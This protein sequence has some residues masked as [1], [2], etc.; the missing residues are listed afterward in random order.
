MKIQPLQMRG[1]HIIYVN[2]DYHY[3]QRY[4]LRTFFHHV[5]TRKSEHA[6]YRKWLH[7]IIC[8][9]HTTANWNKAHI[10]ITAG[11]K[12]ANWISLLA[13]LTEYD[14]VSTAAGTSMVIC[15]CSVLSFQ[16]PNDNSVFSLWAYRKFAHVFNGENHLYVT[17]LPRGPTA[18]FSLNQTANLS[19]LFH[20][21]SSPL[22]HLTAPSNKGTS[23][24]AALSDV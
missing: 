17:L 18:Y 8:S 13:V 21:A 14:R 9:L 16:T 6:K 15:Q 22:W 3:C 20:T 4:I 19:L 24:D 11:I 10:V 23:W 12:L 2:H 1:P 7:G 5:L